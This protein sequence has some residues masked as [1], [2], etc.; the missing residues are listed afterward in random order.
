MNTEWSFMVYATFALG[1]AAVYFLLPHTGRS[2]KTAGHVLG[3]AALAATMV[4][5]ASKFLGTEGANIFFYLSAVV[6]VGS[7][8][9]VITHEKPVYS[10]LYFVLT[11]LAITPLLILQEAEFLAVALVII[12]AGAILVTYVFVIMLSQQGGQ[13]MHDRQSREPFLAVFG[14]FVTMAAIAGQMAALPEEKG[15]VGDFAVAAATTAIND[16]GVDNT[17]LV[18]TA[19]MTEYV[20]AFEV[21]G[22]LLLIAMVGAIAMSKKRVPAETALTPMPV[23]GKVG[24][25]VE[26]F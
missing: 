2:T 11:V 26:P 6:A 20:V 5:C 10:A 7:A 8:V 12:Y 3:V 4:L 9:K 18:G 23:P 16:R 17:S 25:E 24:R 22:V 15:I 14:G 19:M 1:A 21:A 13:P